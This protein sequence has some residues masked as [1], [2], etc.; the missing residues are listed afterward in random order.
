MKDQLCKY[1]PIYSSSL[2]PS[3]NLCSNILQNT[4]EK[5]V[6]EFVFVCFLCVLC[7]LRVCTCVC[8]FMCVQDE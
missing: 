5:D 8:F 3:L 6:C 4:N 2:K 7:C 1:N